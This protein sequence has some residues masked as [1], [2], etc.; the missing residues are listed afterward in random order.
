MSAESRS[1]RSP[2]NRQLRLRTIDFRKRCRRCHHEMP[3]VGSK[4]SSLSAMRS[5]R[6]RRA[7]VVLGVEAASFRPFLPPSNRCRS[8]LSDRIRH[9]VR[10][11]VRA[12]IGAWKEAF[13]LVEGEA[14]DALHV[15]ALQR[16]AGVQFDRVRP[17]D[18]AEAVVAA[19]TQGT[20]WP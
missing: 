11:L 20:A 14:C 13:L 1:Q 15:A 3:P 12:M 10:R 17:G 6:R 18:S 4:V 7:A 2:D 16:N 5:R 19:R 8:R 9:E